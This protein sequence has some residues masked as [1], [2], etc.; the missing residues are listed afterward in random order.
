M[1]INKKEQGEFNVLSSNFDVKYQRSLV[2]LERTLAI[3]SGIPGSNDRGNETN[4]IYILWFRPRTS[5]QK[6]EKNSDVKY[7]N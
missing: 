4:I 6:E 3:V 2:Q 7:L 1:K 5:I